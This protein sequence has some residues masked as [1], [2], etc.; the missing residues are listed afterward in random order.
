M[1]CIY[2]MILIKDR[3]ENYTRVLVGHEQHDLCDSYILYVVH[4]ATENHFERG[5]FG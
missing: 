1:G 4:D 5:K 3:V 2:L